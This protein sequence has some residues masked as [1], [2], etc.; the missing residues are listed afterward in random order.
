MWSQGGTETEWDIKIVMMMVMVFP[1]SWAKN[2][3]LSMFSYVDSLF[4]SLFF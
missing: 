2:N 3:C 4:V 1:D